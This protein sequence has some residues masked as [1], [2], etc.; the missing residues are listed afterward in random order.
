MRKSSK[1]LKNKEKVKPKNIPIPM[2][3]LELFRAL[4]EA[5]ELSVKQVKNLFSNLENVIAAHLK[6]SGA[7]QFILPGIAK[8]I[9]KN[10]PATKA[11]KGT[12]PFTGEEMIFKAKPARNMIK[13]KPLK[14]L[15]AMV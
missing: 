2:K 8:I 7:Q 11:R 1:S 6:K 13:I 4:A 5:S 9:V 14:N 15:K 10:K 12:N 3:K